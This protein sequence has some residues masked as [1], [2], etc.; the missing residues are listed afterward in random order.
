VDPALRD[1]RGIEDAHSDTIVNSDKSEIATCDAVLAYAESASWG[2]AMEVLFAW[3]LRK[4][5]V[6]VCSG[7][8]SPWL[9]HHSDAVLRSVAD[10]CAALLIMGAR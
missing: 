10:A 5:V 8:V 1:F 9:R 2:T 7:P 4:R 3:Q 6:A